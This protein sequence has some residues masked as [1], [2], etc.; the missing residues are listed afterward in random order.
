MAHSSLED[1]DSDVSVS[2]SD[3]DDDEPVLPP[4]AT[5]IAREMLEGTRTQVDST[6]P[7]PTRHEPAPQ[8]PPAIKKV[9]TLYNF[10]M[11][12]TVPVADIVTNRKEAQKELVEVEPEVVAVRRPQL[13]LLSPFSPLFSQTFS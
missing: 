12:K 8:P 10:Y 4:S 2:D 5:R 13:P 7:A 1:R 9:N 3:N 11:V 6:R